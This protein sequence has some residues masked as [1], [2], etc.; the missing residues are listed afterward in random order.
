MVRAWLTCNELLGRGANT[1]QANCNTVRRAGSQL[2]PFLKLQQ[3]RNSLPHAHEPRRPVY[4][5]MQPLHLTYAGVC[6]VRTQ[7]RPR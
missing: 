3:L 7:T 6:T 2:Q 4:L 1:S 5:H